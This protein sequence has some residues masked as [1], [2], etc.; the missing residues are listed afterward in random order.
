MSTPTDKTIRMLM[1][2]LE[3]PFGYSMED[4]TGRL[5]IGRSTFY[6][7]LDTIKRHGVKVEKE[8]SFYKITNVRLA[9][10]GRNIQT[11][12]DLHLKAL[13]L[14]SAKNKSKKNN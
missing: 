5:E 13:Q 8:G 14:L 4:I 10:T 12:F 2:L 3:N 6:K 11:N 7:Y 1:M 9:K